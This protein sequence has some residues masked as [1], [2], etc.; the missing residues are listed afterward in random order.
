MV[1]RFCCERREG[2]E[3]Y[4]CHQSHERGKGEG[5]KCW[6]SHDRGKGWGGMFKC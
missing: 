1:L 4:K 2:G 6:Q 5:L 3:G